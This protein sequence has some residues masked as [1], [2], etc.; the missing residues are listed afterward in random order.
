MHEHGRIINDHLDRKTDVYARYETATSAPDIRICVIYIYIITVA[1]FVYV[2]GFCCNRQGSCYV[3]E[4]NDKGKRNNNWTTVDGEV[5]LLIN[6]PVLASCP[7]TI[8]F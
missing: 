3:N 8:S 1:S 2:H 5:S 4:G 7:K 6:K